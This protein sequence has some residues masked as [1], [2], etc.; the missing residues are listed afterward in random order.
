[1]SDASTIE[2]PER[3]AMSVPEFARA[4]G[5]SERAAYEAVRRG[6]IEHIHIGRR[7]LIPRWVLNKLKEPQK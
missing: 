3:L 2:K 1:M 6:E 7:V 4:V 5:V